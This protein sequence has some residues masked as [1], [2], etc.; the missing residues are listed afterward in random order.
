MTLYEDMAIELKEFF[1][2]HETPVVYN[3]Y[4]Q[5]DKYEEM[6]ISGKMYSNTKILESLQN[7]FYKYIGKYLSGWNHDDIPIEEGTI[8]FGVKDDGVI[9]GI[10]YAGILTK[11]IIRNMIIN[12]SKKIKTDDLELVLGSIKIDLIAVKPTNS[13]LMKEFK[14]QQ[15]RYNRSVEAHKK[16]VVRYMQWHKQTRKWYCKLVDFLNVPEK[17]SYFL[18]WVKTNCDNKNKSAIIKEIVEWKYI[19]DFKICVKDLKTKPESMIYWLCIFKDL[20]TAKVRPKP[21]ISK[22][23]QINWDKIYHS[24]YWMNY[25]LSQIN[26]HIKFYL[27]KLTIPN[28]KTPIYTEYKGEWIQYKRVEEK[29][30]PASVPLL[31]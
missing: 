24:P 19:K 11:K 7:N 13:N 29:W 1:I 23:Y 14:R 30:G 27:I 2:K 8:Y 15:D 16:S 18:K 28:L 6:I 22:I 31:D 9:S 3:K 17:R 10:P 12:C 25:H 20:V 21:T 5:Y 4:E 26:P